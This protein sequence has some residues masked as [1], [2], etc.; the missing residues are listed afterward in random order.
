MSTKSKQLFASH[1][2][3]SPA[4]F[5]W[6]PVLDSPCNAARQMVFQRAPNMC[7]PCA[8]ECFAVQQGTSVL[9]LQIQPQLFK[10]QCLEAPQT[11]L[12]SPKLYAPCAMRV[13]KQLPTPQILKRFVPPPPLQEPYPFTEH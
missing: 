12:S 3:P 6:V 13:G 1:S 8:V 4:R 5:W 11:E 10:Q 7:A 9:K 2:S